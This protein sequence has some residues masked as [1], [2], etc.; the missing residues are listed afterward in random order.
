MPWLWINCFNSVLKCD[1][2]AWTGWYGKD[3]F[4]QVVFEIHAL[5]SGWGPTVGPIRGLYENQGCV[6][7][8][9]VLGRGRRE[10]DSFHVSSLFKVKWN[11][12]S[13]KESVTSSPDSDALHVLSVDCTGL[14][15]LPCE[16]LCHV[17]LL[18]GQQQWVTKASQSCFLPLPLSCFWNLSGIN[19]QQRTALL[20]T[21]ILSGWLQKASFSLP[22]CKTWHGFFSSF[23]T[24]LMWHSLWFSWSSRPRYKVFVW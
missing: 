20:N 7:H 23:L 3:F 4:P 13:Q 14:Q 1:Q 6:T 12:A 18:C 15:C 10:V 21:S 2:L 24:P 22:V 9:R 17:L 8:Q 16:A 19:I 5:F 11:S